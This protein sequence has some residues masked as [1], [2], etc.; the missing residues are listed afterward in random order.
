VTVARRPRASGTERITYSGQDRALDFTR[1][2][3]PDGPGPGDTESGAERT[4]GGQYYTL[5]RVHGQTGWVRAG[6]PSYSEPR[7]IDPRILL[8][9][10]RARTPFRPSGTQ[11]IGGVRLSVLTATDPFGLTRRDLLPV[12]WTSAEP[13]ASLRVWVD[14]QG[15]VHRMTYSF[16]HWPASILPVTP[17]SKAAVRR[18]HRAERAFTQ[19]ID[20]SARYQKRTGKRAPGR[21]VRLASLREQLWLTMAYPP[22]TGAEVTE[23]TVIYSGIGQ[24]QHIAAPPHLVPTG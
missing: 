3:Y 7:I 12:L 5:S 23:T 15:V 4:V 8:R 19:A 11:M 10:L 6:F 1:R 22:D 14:S 17:V 13:V 18:W 20:R 2:D 24:P 16:R 21:W 9:L